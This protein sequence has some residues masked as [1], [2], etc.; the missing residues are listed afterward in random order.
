MYLQD[1]LEYR[2]KLRVLKVRTLDES[3]KTMFVDDSVPVGQLMVT[4]CSR[5]SKTLTFIDCIPLDSI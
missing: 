3:V 4:I 1:L 2:K 5:M